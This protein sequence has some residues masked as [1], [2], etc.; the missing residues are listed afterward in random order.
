MPS[1]RNEDV[2]DNL[3]QMKR[4]CRSYLEEAERRGDIREAAE[5]RELTARVECMIERRSGDP[6][7]G[8]TRRNDP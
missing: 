8:S 6:D 7:A 5:F 2:L 1:N 4:N 3:Y